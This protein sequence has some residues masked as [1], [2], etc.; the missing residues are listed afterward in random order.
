[1]RQILIDKANRGIT[2]D[3]NSFDVVGGYVGHYKTLD[4]DNVNWTNI[5]LA[6]EYGDITVNLPNDE[7]E[8][9][10]LAR[11]ETISSWRANTLV[12]ISGDI[13]LLGDG[14]MLLV[15]DNV[16]S[17]AANERCI[18]K[19]GIYAQF[20]TKE[21]AEDEYGPYFKVQTMFNQYPWNATDTD[22]AIDEDGGIIIIGSKVRPDALACDVQALDK[23]LLEGCLKRNSDNKIYLD[24]NKCSVLSKHR[25]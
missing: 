22:R 5:T 2:M 3:L 11:Q 10:N 23:V 13:Y 24:E 8:A 19:Y 20:M 1:M 16:D 25:Q 17:V 14:D 21:P 18:G 9:T 6:T 7:D 15:V 12:R 4:E